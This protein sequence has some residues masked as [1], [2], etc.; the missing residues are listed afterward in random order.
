MYYNVFG[1]KVSRRRFKEMC[2][3]AKNRREPHLLGDLV[4][5]VSR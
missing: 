5:A 2:N 3:A 4:R 1:E